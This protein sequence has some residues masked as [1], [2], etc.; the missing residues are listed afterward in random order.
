M[1]L[2]FLRTLRCLGLVLVILA[3]SSCSKNERAF[4]DKEVCRAGISALMGRD[5]STV[6][7]KS[8]IL[9]KDGDPFFLI[10]YRRPNDGQYFDY[11]CKVI[12]ED[13]FWAGDSRKW[14]SDAGTGTSDSKLY[15]SEIDSTLHIHLKY[16]QSEDVKTFNKESLKLT[17]STCDGR[18]CA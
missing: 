16:S 5:I 17:P 6:E 4:T 18:G 3:I 1:A 15:F 13:I 7:L 10:G 14:R 8:T 2:I 11:W 12:D 9:P